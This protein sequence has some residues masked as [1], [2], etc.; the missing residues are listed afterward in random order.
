LSDEEKAPYFK[1]LSKITN[2]ANKSKMLRLLYGDVYC[3]ERRY[4]FGL[5]E[6]NLCRRCFEIESI[7]HLLMQYPYTCTVYSLLGINNRDIN[8]IV[9]LYLSPGELEIRADIL[10]YLLFRQHTMPPQTLVQITME[11]YANGLTNRNGV[12][13][14]AARY[15]IGPG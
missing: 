7:H 9:G 14:I 11:K 12:T 13:N 4:R 8:E 3:V 2:I 15:Q 1:K 6:S 10:C 5:T